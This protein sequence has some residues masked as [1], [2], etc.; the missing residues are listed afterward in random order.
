[1]IEDRVNP[2]ITPWQIDESDFYEL[3]SRAEELVFLLRYAV[4]APSSH[5]TQPWSFRITAKGVEVFADYSRRLPAID[6]DDRELL[7]SVGAAIT[8]LRVAAAWFGFDTTVVYEQRPEETFPV[9]LVTFEETYLADDHLRPLF[10]AIRRRH[11]NRQPFEARPLEFEALGALCDVAD[12][13]PDMVTFLLPRDK[14]RLADL[15][16][17]GDERQM[18]RTAVRWELAEWIRGSGS[19]SGDGI[20]V[21]GLGIPAPLDRLAGWLTRRF[22]L[23]GMQASHD[24]QMITN[25]AAL[26]LIS[27]NN[28]RIS[29]LKAGEVVERLLLTATL[30][31]L[32]YS[33]FNYAIEDRALREEIRQLARSAEPPQLLLRFGYAKPLD[34][35]MPRRPVESVMQKPTL[36]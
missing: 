36:D 27:A 22:D 35:A 31:G 14:R 13:F 34:R 17:R 28:D 6:P 19:D 9:A 21:D 15:V 25:A 29:L 12:Q 8:N 26:I 5:N 1:M 16:A 33:L 30:N 7:M 4:L 10:P 20:C 3:E 2:R 23:G 18:S 11:T 32:Q 24:R